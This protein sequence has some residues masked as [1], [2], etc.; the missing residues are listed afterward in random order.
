MFVL[1]AEIEE[2]RHGEGSESENMSRLI[3]FNVLMKLSE[4]ELY[5]VLHGGDQVVCMGAPDFQTFFFLLVVGF[6]VNNG[7]VV[8]LSLR[9]R[10]KLVPH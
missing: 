7:I 4:S 10:C 1:P 5:C 8:S 2:R 3:L 6:I 9:C